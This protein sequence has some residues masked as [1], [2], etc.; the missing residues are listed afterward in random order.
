MLAASFCA[1]FFKVQIRTPLKIE[2]GSIDS[3]LRHKYSHVGYVGTTAIRREQ[4]NGRPGSGPGV[5]CLFAWFAALCVS[6]LETP[7]DTG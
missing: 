1:R 2:F 4:Q 5:R 7:L 6:R 3:A